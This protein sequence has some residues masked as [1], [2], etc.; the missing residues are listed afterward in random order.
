MSIKAAMWVPGTAARVE[1]PELLTW[2]PPVPGAAGLPPNPP[3]RDITINGANVTFSQQYQSG[4]GNSNWFHF[5]IP[6]PVILDD[7]R[8]QL[9][10]VFIFYVAQV[11]RLKSVHVWDGPNRVW[12]LTT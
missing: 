4:A 11:A 2:R 1:Y 6:T 10:Q 9:L 5:P 7:T 3:Q 12:E 8:V